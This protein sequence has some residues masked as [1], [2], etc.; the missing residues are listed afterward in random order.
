MKL[1]RLKRHAAQ[2]ADALQE[3]Q[4]DLTAHLDVLHGQLNKLLGV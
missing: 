1:E 4:D 3:E 2:Y